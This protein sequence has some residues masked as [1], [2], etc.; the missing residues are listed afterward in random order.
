MWWVI[1]IAFLLVCLFLGWVFCAAAAMQERAM[2][3][4][5]EKMRNDNRIFDRLACK[6][7]E[8]PQAGLVGDDKDVTGHRSQIAGHAA[9]ID[10]RYAPMRVVRTEEAQN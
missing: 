4:E 6:W 2:E 5:E 7:V 1:L 9:P 3:R 8:K 10:R